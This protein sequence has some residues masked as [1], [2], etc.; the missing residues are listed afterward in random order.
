MVKVMSTKL[1]EEL[2]ASLGTAA[3]ARGV[4][5]NYLV[6]EALEAVVEG[7]VRFFTEE[8]RA[9]RRG[10]AV[11]KGLERDRRALRAVLASE[12]P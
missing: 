7:R 8:E 4:T 10:Q 1:P 2:I 12:P 9:S 5:R 3:D 6:R 11:R